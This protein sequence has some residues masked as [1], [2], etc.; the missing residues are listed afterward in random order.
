[1]RKQIIIV[2]PSRSGHNW[3]AKMLSSWVQPGDNVW[4]FEA[5][6]PNVWKNRLAQRVWKGL[7]PNKDDQVI[8]F[9]QLRDYLNFAAS[10]TKYMINHGNAYEPRRVVKLFEIWHEMALEA[11]NETN[12]IPDKHILDYDRFVADEPYRRTICDLMGGIYSEEM[13]D[14]VPK[15]GMGSTFDKFKYQDNGREMQVRERWKW[16]LTEEG[17]YYHSYLG[18]KPE[19]LRY[20]LDHF[21]TSEEQ[22]KLATEILEK[23]Q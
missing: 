5:V 19:I 1:M 20:Y 22:R 6:P 3:T 16:F 8:T 15:G 21:E 9:I 14:F 4:Q 18:A 13:I 11:H 10:W 7:P 23:W 2:A 17:Q 12:Y